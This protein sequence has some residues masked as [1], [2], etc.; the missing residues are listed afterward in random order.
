MTGDYMLASMYFNG[1]SCPLLPCLHKAS[2]TPLSAVFQ[3]QLRKKRKKGN[4]NTMCVS[5]FPAFLDPPKDLTRQQET[6]SVILANFDI[7]STII[8]SLERSGSRQKYGWPTDNTFSTHF[9]FCTTER[10]QR[11]KER[12]LYQKRNSAK[13]FAML[14]AGS[15]VVIYVIVDVNSTVIGCRTVICKLFLH[16]QVSPRGKQCLSQL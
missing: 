12:S 16:S 10:W 11:Q 4:I 3:I 1:F 14:F 7:W 8:I 5:G 6:I 13:M 9:C 15:S 2:F